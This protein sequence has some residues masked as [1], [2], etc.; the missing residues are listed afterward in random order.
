[1]YTITK[2][3]QKGGGT[4]SYSYIYELLHLAD[5]DHLENITVTTWCA[6]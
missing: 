6:N 4:T 5:D 1:M 3:E 2:V